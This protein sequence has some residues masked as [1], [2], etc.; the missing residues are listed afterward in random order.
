MLDMKAILIPSAGVAG[1]HIMF[2]FSVVF[3]NIVDILH[4][5]VAYSDSSEACDAVRFVTG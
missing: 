3:A 5:L 4:I 2:V 1:G